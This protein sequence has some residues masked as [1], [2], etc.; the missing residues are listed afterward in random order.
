MEI[1]NEKVVNLIQFYERHPNL[2]MPTLQER[3]RFMRVMMDQF[4]RQCIEGDAP[5]RPTSDD[6]AA[7]IRQTGV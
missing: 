1:T 2:K 4:G 3:L 5:K 6:I 7:A